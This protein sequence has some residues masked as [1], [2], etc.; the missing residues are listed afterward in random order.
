MIDSQFSNHID[1]TR[2]IERYQEKIETD[3]VYDE[4]DLPDSFEDDEL[5]LSQELDNDSLITFSTAEL[6]PYNET[7]PP[8]ISTESVTTW[9]PST[10]TTPF[11]T[12]ST[13]RPNGGRKKQKS[14]RGR[15]RSSEEIDLRPRKKPKTTDSTDSL[16]GSSTTPKK[17]V[18]ESNIQFVRPERVPENALP[19][20]PVSTNS[21]I[22][23]IKPSQGTKNLSRK[24][25]HFSDADLEFEIQSVDEDDFIIRNEET[26]EIIRPARLVG[27]VASENVSLKNRELEGL[28]G[29]VQ[30]ILGNQEI[31]GKY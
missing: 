13:R 3:D 1:E 24:M 31:F 4:G 29:F 22:I 18:K 10:S 5:D 7:F 8:P 14:D 28:G 17:K 19:S 30:R 9:L 25:R 2:L 26:G 6:D 20:T 16:N 11:T 15:N 27:G 12:E 21:K 23:E